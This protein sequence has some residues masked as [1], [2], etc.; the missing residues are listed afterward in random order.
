MG[1]WWLAVSILDGCSS[2]G[3][4]SDSA[5][6]GPRG[7]PRSNLHVLGDQVQSF[8]FLMTQCIYSLSFRGQ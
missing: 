8:L 2:Q 6:C 3:E 1:Q 7:L 4:T 5:D